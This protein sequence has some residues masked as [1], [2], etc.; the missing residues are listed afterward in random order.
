MA[1]KTVTLTFRAEVDLYARL[2][3]V[4]QAFGTPFSEQLRRGIELWLAQVEGGGLPRS[5]ARKVAGKKR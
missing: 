2:D 5:P 1:P 4:R 3:A